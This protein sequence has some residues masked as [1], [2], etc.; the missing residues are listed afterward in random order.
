VAVYFSNHVAKIM[1]HRRRFDNRHGYN[2]NEEPWRNTSI[3]RHTNHN[4]GIRDVVDTPPDATDGERVYGT[5]S[6]AH[7]RQYRNERQI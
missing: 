2:R 7:A 3:R 5:T 1:I 6:E 4:H